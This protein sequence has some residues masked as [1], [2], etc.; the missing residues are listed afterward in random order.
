MNKE[1]IINVEEQEVKIALLEDGLLVEL[2]KEILNK[3]FS[4]GDVYLGIVK[5]IL[6]G[7]N[8][9]IVDIGNSQCGFLHY[10]DLGYQIKN[11]FYFISAES[12]PFSCQNKN[13]GNEHI[14]FECEKEEKE[15]SIDDILYSGQKILVQIAKE[16]ISN[17][18]IKLTSKICIPGRSLVLIPFSEKIS[19]SKKIKDNKEKERLFSYIDKIKPKNVGVIIRT[20]SVYEKEKNLNQELTFLI[21]K[22]ENVI[23]NL[24]KKPPVRILSETNKTHIF[25][26]DVFNDDFKFIYCNN[27]FLCKEIHSYLSLISPKR[28]S[29]IQFDPG[30]I[31]IFEKY[32]IE[33]Q[34]QT[35]LGKNVPL[36]NGAYIVIEH[37]EAL[38]VIDVNSGMSNHMKKNCTEYERM[39]NI[40]NINLLAAT[41]ISRQLRLRDMGGII[42]VDF[43]D[44]EDPDQK[45]KLYDHLKEK[46]KKDRAKHQILPPNEFG[47]VEFTRHRVRP[48]LKKFQYNNKNYTLSYIFCLEFIIENI[49]KKY[50]NDINIQLHIHSFVSAYLKK[51]FPSIQQKWFVKYK[52][53]IKLVSQD[54]FKYTEYKIINNNREILYSI[55]PLN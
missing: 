2:H 39:N 50:E 5:K 53:W 30:K 26:R 14:N 10:S 40:F 25:L 41:E 55:F 35:F 19:I 51:G 27:R 1:L 49:L 18:K 32:G 8:A 21:Q 9:A 7:L 22:W 48:E 47:L 4:V 12:I 3:K 45:K 13:I 46:M 16:P 42:V 34:I 23:T 29:I 24:V 31:P 54:S 17:K 36:E 44:M 15:I 33:K 28:T 38:H 20:A 11:M 37:T 43:I 52:I 6:H